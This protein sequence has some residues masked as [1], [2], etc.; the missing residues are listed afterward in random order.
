MDVLRGWAD[1]CAR[2]ARATLG[3]PDLG[4][5]RAHSAAL[6]DFRDEAGNRRAV[7]RPMLAWIWGA[8]PGPMPADAATDVRLWWNLHAERFDDACLAPGA[9]APLL[10]HRPGTVIEVWTESELSG[11]HALWHAAVRFGRDDLRRRALAA[12][13]WHVETMQPDNATNRA[14]AVHVFAVLSAMGSADAD[15]YAQTLL[16]NCSVAQGKP[17]V[18]S[19]WLL[20]DSARA[21]TAIAGG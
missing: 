1:R 6:T 20:M 13:A 9:S 21:L 16:H 15:L 4:E 5:L 3:D 14:W 7:D 11:L 8:R 10:T 2:A 18:L 12:G 17:D 19:A